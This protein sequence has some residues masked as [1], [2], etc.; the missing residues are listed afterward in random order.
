MNYIWIVMVLMGIGFAAVNGTLPQFSD[1][2]MSSCEEAVTFVIGLAGVMAV[3]SGIMEIARGSGLISR[4]AR[5]SRPLMGF[6]FP[7]EKDD[8]TIGAM[9]MSFTANLF[10]AGN[11]ATVFSLRAMERLDL[12]NGGREDASDEMCMFLA[13]SMSM[14][15]LIPI[16]IMKIRRDAGSAD[17]GSIIVPSIV[18]GLVSMVVSVGVCRFFE[19]WGRKRRKKKWP[20]L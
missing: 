15:Q 2:L 11:S 4:V 16:T 13:L 20:K 3:W 9:L 10:G 14:I 8:E 7:R 5:L 18:A 17:P 1:G 19:G 6:L 12:E